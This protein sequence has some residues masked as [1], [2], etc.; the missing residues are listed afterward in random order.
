MAV[1][2]WDELSAIEQ[3]LARWEYTGS[4]LLAE[5]YAD[6]LGTTWDIAMRPTIDGGFMVF[7]IPD[8]P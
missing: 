8:F 5:Q 3:S 6:A 2:R 4:Q 1:R 7:T